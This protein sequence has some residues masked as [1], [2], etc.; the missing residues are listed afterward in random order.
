MP[1]V[2]YFSEE[3]AL[4]EA[5]ASGRIDAVARGEIGNRAAARAH[6][7]AF[8]VTALDNRAEIGGFALGAEDAALAACLD[9]QIDRLTDGGRIGYSDWLYDPSVFMRRAI[10]GDTVQR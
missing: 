7:D 9:R 6:G 1:T 2:I 10:T 5:L 8:A 3:T 4:I